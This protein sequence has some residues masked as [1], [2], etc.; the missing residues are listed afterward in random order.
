MVVKSCQ[1]SPT[2]T[3]RTPRERAW[4]LHL[5]VLGQV[6][7][8]RV[9]DGLNLLPGK[10]WARDSA[11]N[12][13]T[14]IDDI[15]SNSFFDL[16]TKAWTLA[17]NEMLKIVLWDHKHQ[18]PR[19]RLCQGWGYILSVETCMTTGF[20]KRVLMETSGWEPGRLMMRG[21]WSPWEQENHSALASPD[22][23]WG[24]SCC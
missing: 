5:K 12:M 23:G 14:R 13:L 3:H 22:D 11:S 21:H 16:L 1:T 19:L 7:K 4:Q 17:L 6:K 8:N 9:L 24:Y 15:D 10:P 18:H 2:V 20:L